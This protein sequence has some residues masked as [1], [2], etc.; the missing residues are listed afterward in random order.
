MRSTALTS[1]QPVAVLGGASSRPITRPTSGQ[2]IDKIPGVTAWTTGAGIGKPVIRGLSANN[3]LVLANGQRTDTQQWADEHSP[4]IETSDAER[5]EVIKG[6]ASVLYGSDAVGGVVNVI[7]ARHSRCH[8]HQGEGRRQDPGRVRH[9]QHQP[10]RH[11][12]C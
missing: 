12:A 9:Q 10:R 8:R 1:P 2:T 4:N 11:A 6:P 3:V 7:P 5:I